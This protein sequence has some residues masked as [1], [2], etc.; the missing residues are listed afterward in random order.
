MASEARNVSSTNIALSLRGIGGLLALPLVFCFG[1]GVTKVVLLWLHFGLFF[2]DLQ[3]LDI[4]YLEP[5][6]SFSLLLLS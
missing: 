5:G 3:V 4:V 6:W 2:L 1:C